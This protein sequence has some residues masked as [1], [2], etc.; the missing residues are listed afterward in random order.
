MKKAAT[1]NPL[2]WPTYKRLRNQCTC[3]IRKAIQD[4]YHG[5]IEETNDDPKKMWKTI[6]RGLNRDSVSKSN[7]S[8][9]VDDIV[10]TEG[11][12]LAGALNQH[13]FSV[14]P[15]LAEKLKLHQVTIHL[16]ISNRTIQLP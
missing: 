11:G 7:S 6:N 10:V 1:K 15:K 2:L 12:E 14:G 16:N 13:F 8:L 4:H 3:A 5:L 9:N